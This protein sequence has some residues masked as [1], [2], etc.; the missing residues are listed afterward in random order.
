MSIETNVADH[1]TRGQLEDS[2]LQAL[3]RAGKDVRN[4]KHDDLAVLDEFHIGG[5]EATQ[6][7][8]AQMDLRP[9]LRLL[10]VGSGI[11]GPARYFAAEQA[12]K[13]TGIDLTEEFVQVAR[14]LTHRT[15]LDNS[16]EFF[17]GSALAL[18][19]EPA[20]F[21]RAYT[22]HACMNIKDKPLLFREVRRVLK[23]GG[24]FAIFDLMR[25][26]EG[27]IRYPVPWAPTEETSF[28]AH[29]NDYSEALSAAGFQVTHERRRG[30]FALEFMQRVMARVAQSGPPVLGLHLLMGEQ[31]KLMLSNVNAMVQEGVLEP[32][33]LVAR[34]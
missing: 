23:P 10:D 32:V 9:G 31:T 7:L 1:Y 16:V 29:V 3:A 34:V 27:P 19:F 14:S 6:D 24:L 30:A 2:I 12:C 8:A 5:R 17:H 13:V 26:G 15:N 18:P 25:I 28:V 11:G 22:I 33:E 21:D 4:L 20:T